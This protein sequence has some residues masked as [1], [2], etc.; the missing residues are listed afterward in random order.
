MNNSA[1][2]IGIVE[3]DPLMGESLQRALRLEGWEASWWST[4]EQALSAL[5]VA[6]PDLILCDMRLPDMTGADIFRSARSNRLQPPFIFMTAFGQIEEAVSLMRA[7]ALDY[8]TK[9]FDLDHLLARTREM[10]I[11]RSRDSEGTALGIS[12]QMRRIETLLRRV[13]HRSMPVLLTGETGS[14]K[15]VCARFLHD[16]SERANQPFMAVNCAAI[17]A[18]LLESELF[19]HE[20]GAFSGAQ[21][22]HLGYAERA[23]TGTLFLDEIG[24]MPIMLQVKLLR[25]LE[26]RHFHRLGG[27]T[28]IALKARVV[29]ATSAPLA[30][31]VEQG[32]FRE[33]LLYRINVLT[34]DIP[35]LRERRDD[36]CWLMNRFFHILNDAEDGSLRGIGASVEETARQHPW[37][38]NVRELRNRIE[39]AVA[40]AAGPWLMVADVFPE[41]RNQLLQL[42]DGDIPLV[43]VRDAAE[44]RQIERILQ[45]TDAHIGLT[46]KRLGISRTTLWEKMTRY[47]LA[48]G[49]AEPRIS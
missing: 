8:I 22:R 35:P 25:M 21:H 48:S 7:G 36:I 30:G 2:H 1:L 20:R 46:A 18:E 39:R 40:L 10:A 13:G 12:P 38:G 33:D 9:P 24:D 44:R 17:P 43:A 47:G 15:E 5:P 32:R 11:E 45:E 14:G 6:Q 4:G 34:V 23:G 26:D 16:V 37:R 41:V 42:V 29:C 31:M 28:P 3:D 19:G 49:K 27:E